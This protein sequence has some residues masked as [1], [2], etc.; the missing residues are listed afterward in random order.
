MEG[1]DPQGG[2]ANPLAVGIDVIRP[3]AVGILLCQRL[4]TEIDV[5][6][7]VGT[8]VLAYAVALRIVGVEVSA[9]I[10]INQLGLCIIT[11]VLIDPSHDV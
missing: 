3:G 10:E 6:R 7:P 4:A 2:A 9:V 11:I 5:L 8:G 1:D